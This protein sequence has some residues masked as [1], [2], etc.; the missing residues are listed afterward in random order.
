MGE[1][2]PGAPRIS[3][4]RFEAL[5]RVLAR[6]PD[7]RAFPACITRTRQGAARSLVGPTNESLFILAR[8]M[9]HPP[10]VVK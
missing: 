2:L 9:A 4:F 5:R 6:I 8:P 1:F 7:P 10:D 3:D